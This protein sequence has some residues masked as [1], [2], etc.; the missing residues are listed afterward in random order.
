MVDS[1]IDGSVL[2]LLLLLQT[3]CWQELN[4]VSNERVGF[5]FVFLQAK[6]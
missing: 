1:I 4:V 3:K 2:I 6:R 5:L